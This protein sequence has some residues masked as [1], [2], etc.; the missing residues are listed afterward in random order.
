MNR[1]LA[2]IPTVASLALAVGLLAASC[3]RA[4]ASST[5]STPAPTST[6]PTAQAAAAEREAE[7][8]VEGM[9]CGTCPLTVKTAAQRV[10][11]VIDA[12]VSIESGR[13]WVHYRPAD[14]GPEAI[15]VAI[16]ESGYPAK[17]LHK[18]FTGAGR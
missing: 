12:R 3:Q 17:E 7:F 11:G 8:V 10:H 14:T 4:P 15:A 2:S 5:T 18:E 16:S 13:A 6:T 1:S 9:H